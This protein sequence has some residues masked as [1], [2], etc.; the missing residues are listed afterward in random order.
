MARILVF[1]VM[2]LQCLVVSVSF[3]DQ[4]DNPKEQAMSDALDLWR[5]GRF[6]QLYDR[7]SH[8]SGLTR[9]NF[10]SQMRDSGIR[11]SCCFQKLSEFRVISEKRTTAKVFAKIGMEGSAANDTRSREFTLDHEEGMWKMRLTDIRKLAGVGAKKHK[12]AVKVK[13]YH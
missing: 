12:K 13:N 10:A 1:F 2:I 5:E 3:A 7:L 8:R 6:E 11:P 9:E 4:R